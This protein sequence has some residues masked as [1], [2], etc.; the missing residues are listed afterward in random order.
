[1]ADFCFDGDMVDYLDSSLPSSSE[2]S[3][4]CFSSSVVEAMTRLYPNFFGFTVAA[5]FLPASS[6]FDV[7]YV[8]LTGGFFFGGLCCC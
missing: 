3:L 2:T 1:M 6:L 7:F 8:S 5:A 4:T